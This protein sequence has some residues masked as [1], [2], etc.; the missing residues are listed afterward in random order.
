MVASIALALG[1]G[2]APAASAAP[3]VADLARAQAD[4]LLDAIGATP[5][6]RAALGRAAVDALAE[7]DSIATVEAARVTDELCAALTGPKVDR[8]ALEAARQDGMALLDRSSAEL[9]PRLADAL[10]VLTPEQRAALARRL[11]REAAAVLA[12]DQG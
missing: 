11:Q 4:E 9:L 12:P 10:D 3:P 7:L 2:F 1:L 8:E 5:A 6:Q